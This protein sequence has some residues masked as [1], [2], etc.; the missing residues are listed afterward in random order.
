MGVVE[1]VRT[2]K[3]CLALFNR[4]SIEFFG[5]FLEDEKTQLPQY[6]GDQVAAKTLSHDNS[7]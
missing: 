1:C 6:T 5:S 2:L 7:S 4:N 3:E